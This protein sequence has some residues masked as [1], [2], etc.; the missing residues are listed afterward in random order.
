M[1]EQRALG[2]V[3]QTAEEL[4]LLVFEQWTQTMLTSVL[5]LVGA[6]VA[7]LPVEVPL[8]LIELAGKP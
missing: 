6:M 8:P 7:V 2:L 3:E 4:Y 5:Y 1:L